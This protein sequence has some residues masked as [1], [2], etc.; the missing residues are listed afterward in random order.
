VNKD[1]RIWTLRGGWSWGNGGWTSTPTKGGGGSSLKVKEN[2]DADY[3]EP[4]E[5]DDACTGINEPSNGA[6][7]WVALYY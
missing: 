2:M 4:K 5:K 6:D 7:G 3:I 1:K